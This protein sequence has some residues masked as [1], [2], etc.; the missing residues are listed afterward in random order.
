RNAHFEE[1]LFE[2][3]T[4]SQR[5]WD[6]LSW[7][8]PR[9]MTSSAGMC[10][11]DDSVITMDTDLAEEFDR[12]FHKAADRPCD[13]SIVDELPSDPARDW[14][15]FSA[16]ELTDALA[17]CSPKSAPGPDHLTWKM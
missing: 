13:L 11:A 17:T 14:P 2:V 8:K 5:V 1:R 10:R 16:L 6:L 15:P 4:C 3:S 9:R 7:V 12:T